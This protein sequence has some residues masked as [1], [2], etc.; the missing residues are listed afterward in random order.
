M[1]RHLMVLGLFG[2]LSLCA[3]DEVAPQPTLTDMNTPDADMFDDQSATD[4]SD[5]TTEMLDMTPDLP[6]QSDDM[7]MDMSVMVPIALQSSI[8]QVQ[9]MTGIVLWSDSWNDHPLKTQQGATQLEY[10]YVRPSDIVD[11]TGQYDWQPFEALLNDVASRKH[12]LIV[13]FYY[14]YPGRQTAV[15]DHIKKR[16]SY[17]ETRGQ[18]EGQTTWFPDWRDDGLEQFHLAFYTKFAQRY[19]NDPRLAFLQVGFGLWGEYHIYDGPNIIG[20]HFPSKTFQTT[21]FNHMKATFKRL[22][23]SVSIDAGSQT[24]SP[25]AM[26]AQLRQSGFGLFDDSFMHKEHNGYNEQMWDVFE[27]NTR[28]LTQPHGGELSYY[29]AFDQQNALNAQGIHGRTFESMSGKFHI[30]Y[31]IGNDQPAHQSNARIKAAAMATGYRFEITSLMSNAT[32]TVATVQNN[33]VAPFYYDAW[34][35]IDGVRGTTSLKGLQ[36]GQSTQV[37]I[38]TP[39]TNASLVEVVADRLV[40]GQRIEF[41]AD[42]K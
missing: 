9:P 4:L 31:M 38:L 2:V 16:A 10:A 32:Q 17:Q 34:V 24:Y 33:G 8:T 37:N 1:K 14:V 19:D 11:D 20:E 29:T 18:T 27:H 13:R 15:P 40:P 23:W 5:I 39:A 42:L 22:K 26:D 7:S 3:C 35:S 12:Q 36:P 28:Y 30:S 21:F 6:D 25:L 41:Q